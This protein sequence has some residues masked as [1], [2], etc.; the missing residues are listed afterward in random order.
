VSDALRRFADFRVS[1]S[2][3]EGT[4]SKRLHG[5]GDINTGYCR[6][7]YVVGGSLGILAPILI[8]VTENVG[9]ILGIHLD[10]RADFIKGMIT[11]ILKF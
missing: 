4:S 1:A 5:G 9:E 10:V 6:R 7:E 3:S 2:W 8:F 11:L